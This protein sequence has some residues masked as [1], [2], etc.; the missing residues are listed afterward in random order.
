MSI[1]PMPP[2]VVEAS[3]LARLIID[4][5]SDEVLKN[6]QT[7]AELGST[8]ESYTWRKVNTAL[9]SCAV[10]LDA[11]MSGNY[12]YLAEAADAGYESSLDDRGPESVADVLTRIG[13]DLHVLYEGNMNKTSDALNAVIGV[14]N[15][16]YLIMHQDA[17]TPPPMNRAARRQAARRR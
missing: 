3:I 13:D 2:E 5:W 6:A 12:D 4:R 10:L 17:V 1:T 7:S 8:A 16:S 11:A 15:D 14:M 9:R